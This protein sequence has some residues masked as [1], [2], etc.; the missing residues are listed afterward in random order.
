LLNRDREPIKPHHFS[1][2]YKCNKLGKELKIYP[3]QTSLENSEILS[4][5]W[6]ALPETKEARKYKRMKKAIA[7]LEH[8]SMQLVYC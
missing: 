1:D 3:G 5:H 6:G 4:L 7:N 8:N 2:A